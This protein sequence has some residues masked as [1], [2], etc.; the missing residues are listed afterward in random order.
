MYMQYE[1]LTTKTDVIIV[2]LSN[3]LVPMQTIESTGMTLL[4]TQWSYSTRISHWRRLTG[5]AVLDRVVQ[6]VNEL[7]K[8]YNNYSIHMYHMRIVAVMIRVTDG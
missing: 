5:S 3:C 4:S 2:F 8:P 1:I 7:G 6:A